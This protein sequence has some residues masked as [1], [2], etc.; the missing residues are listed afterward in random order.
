MIKLI[1]E[2][3]H[4]DLL[5]IQE[6]RIMA[7]QAAEAHEKAKELSQQQVD[8]I[9]KAMAE[10]GEANAEMLAAMAV[11][12]TGYGNVRDKTTKNLVASKMLYEAIKDM[13]TVGIIAEYPERRMFEVG[14]SVG[15]VTALIP[16]TNPT[17]TTIYKSIICMKSGNPVIFSPHPAAKKSMARACEIMQQAASAAGAPDNMFQCPKHIHMSGTKELMSNSNIKMILATGG[18]E[19]VKAAYSSGIP[20]LGVGPGNVPAFIERSADVSKA[21]SR[22]LVS[23]TFDNGVICASEQAIV[24]EDCILDKVIGELRAQGCFILSDDEAAKFE[25]VITKGGGRLNPQIVGKTA[26]AIAAMAGVNVP[27]DTR[28]LVYQEKGVGAKFPFSIEKLSP[29]LALYSETD[30]VKACE[31]CI[32]ILEFGGIGHTLAIHSE[33]D[34]VI[35]EFAL[36]KPVSRLLVNTPSTHGAIGA[37]TGLMPALTLGCGSVGGSA[38]SDNVTPLNLINVRRVAYGTSDVEETAPKQES[39]IDMAKLTQAIINAIKEL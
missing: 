14:V 34:A 22:I 3:N 7:A 36:K 13:K 27:P 11:E 28:V 31:R 26:T 20:A 10:A 29:L 8:A 6:A 23:K 1:S 5:A 16:S 37:T 33:N 9:V 25:F 21:V 2:L 30:W 39:G 35:R 17:S 19:M 12:E 32:E 18:K 15:T 24:T 4:T 38:T